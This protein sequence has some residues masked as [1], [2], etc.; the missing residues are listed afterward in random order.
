MLSFRLLVR[1]NIRQNHPFGNHTVLWTPENSGLFWTRVWCIPEFGAENKSALFFLLFWGFEGDFKTCAKPRYAPNSG[2]NASEKLRLHGGRGIWSPDKTRTII[3]KPALADTW[4]AGG[5]T[6]PYTRETG[7]IWQIGVLTAEW[8]LFWTPKKRFW[9]VSCYIFYE[10]ALSWNTSKRRYTPQNEIGM[11]FG[12]QFFQSLRQRYCTRSTLFAQLPKNA[13]NKLLENICGAR[14][15]GLV[16]SYR[17]M[18]QEYRCTTPCRAHLCDTPFCNISRDNRAI[19][20]KNNRQIVLRCYPFK[21]CAIWKVSREGD[22]PKKP[23]TQ[24]KRVRKQFAQIISASFLLILKGKRGTVCTNCAEIV[25][26]N[27]VFI[28]VGG[29][30][31]GSPLHE[32]SLWASKP[33][34]TLG[35]TWG[36]GEVARLLQLSIRSCF[37]VLWRVPFG[38][39]SLCPLRWGLSEWAGALTL[40]GL[41]S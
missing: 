30:W 4:R 41:V 2:W 26:A 24:I 27:C 38:P 13:L 20:H 1:E 36:T 17:A 29:F 16:G 15:E 40:W 5:N 34:G 3:W 10:K 7:T 9:A 21:H 6:S 39:Y 12:N 37:F 8:S 33:E 14:P 25:C 18:L 28:W 11:D 22:P 32:R 31:G 19:S 23:P 35:W